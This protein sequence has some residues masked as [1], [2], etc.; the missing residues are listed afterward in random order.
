MIETAQKIIKII[1][2]YGRVSTSNQENEGTIETQLSAVIQYAEKNSYIIVQKYVDEGW[3]GDSLARPALDQLRQDAKKKLW[4]AVLIYDPDRLARRYSYQELVMDELKEAGVEV[5]FVTVPVAKNDEDKIMYGMR[6]LFSQYERMKIAERFRLGKVRKARENHIIATEAPYG[7]TFIPKKGKRGDSDFHQG[8]YEINEI[9]AQTVRNIFS[10]VADEGLTLR[11]IVRKLQSLGIQ[12]RKSKRGVWNTSTLS[13]LLRNKTYIGEAHYGASYAIV[14][15]NPLKKDLYKKNKKT[16]R[17][18][19]PES[20]WIK[21]T[22]PKIIEADLFERVQKQLKSNFDL[23]VRNKKN[24]YLLGNR[25]WCVCGSRRTGE[26]PMHGKH[27]YYR[28]SDRVN[29][30]PLPS[31]CNEKISLNAR[32][33]DTLVWSRLM[34]LMTSPE[35]IFQQIERWIKSKQSNAHNLIDDVTIIQKEI[36]KLE[37]QEDRYNKAYGSG[38]FSIEQLREYADPVKEKISSLKLQIAQSQAEKVQTEISLPDQNAIEKFT[39]KV[40]YRLENL[41]FDVKKGIVMNVVEKIIAT[42][43]NL[44]VSGCITITANNTNNHVEFI[45]SHR[46][47]WTAKRRQINII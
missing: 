37:T 32:I 2:I 27:L 23:C 46:N 47:C 17:R 9:E 5:L 1:A 44:M 30:F 36:T 31:T 43:D 38:A 26:G 39:D 20:E 25:I 7:Y 35:L 18:I 33:A 22:S 11:G 12:P 21:I 42:H 41:N 14:P 3:S 28:C 8:Y 6:G 10:W 4:D 13:T 40:K 15:L 29:S 34:E 45:S 16:S 19:R 24:E